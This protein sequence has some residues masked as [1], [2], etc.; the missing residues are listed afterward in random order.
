[1]GI[2]GVYMFETDLVIGIVFPGWTRTTG[3]FGDDGLVLETDSWTVVPTGVVDASLTDDG[4]VL[5]TSTSGVGNIS[6]L[7]SG[8][9]LLCFMLQAL[10]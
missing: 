9:L 3:S 10:L 7:A 1:M 4:A 5:P 6:P 2:V 8:L